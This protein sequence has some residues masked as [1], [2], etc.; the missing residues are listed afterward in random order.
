[1]SYGRLRSWSSPSALP[2]HPSETR[3]LG[4]R[5]CDRA[6]C[7]R[8]DPRGK[9]GS[10]SPRI[11]HRGLPK[12]GRRGIR[13]RPSEASLRAGSACIGPSPLRLVPSPVRPKRGKG[14]VEGSDTRLRARP[15][16][17]RPRR[18]RSGSRPVHVRARPMRLGCRGASPGRSD[19]RLR[20][21]RCAFAR[22]RYALG[23]GLCALGGGLCALGG[24]PCAL[25][26]GQ[27]ASGREVPLSGPEV[28]R[29]REIRAPPGRA[30]CA[31]ESGIAVWSSDTA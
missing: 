31:F 5:N 4:C 19:T 16:R 3:S 28:D 13:Q 30:T 7:R 1:M 15:M 21:S 29:L 6:T 18:V 25:G 20:A 8:Y 9:C 17:P 11:F 26:E 12:K 22:G 27:C 24:G 2:R 23:G 14:S 10:G